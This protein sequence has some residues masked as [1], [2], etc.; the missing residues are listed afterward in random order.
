[1]SF[2][3]MVRDPQFQ[4]EQHRRSGHGFLGLSTKLLCV[5]PVFQTLA[6]FLHSAGV[7]PT[8]FQRHSVAL[9]H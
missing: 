7:K 8:T 5:H 4:A 2:N 1:M 9:I 3:F 6:N